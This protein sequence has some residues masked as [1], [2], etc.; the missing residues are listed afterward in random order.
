[1]AII[2]VLLLTVNISPSG[3]FYFR[4]SNVNQIWI[5]LFFFTV[6][7]ILTIPVSPIKWKLPKW[8]YAPAIILAIALPNILS[9]P[10]LLPFFQKA[11]KTGN[12]DEAFFYEW[13]K[14]DSL[15]DGEIENR[16][17]VFISANCKYC[18]FTMHKVNNTVAKTPLKYS[19]VL[20]VFAGTFKDPEAYFNLQ[21][22]RVFPHIQLP[23]QTVFSMS[24][25][26]SVPVILQ[27][28]AGKVVNTFNFRS[29]DDRK[30]IKTLLL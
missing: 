7:I 22:L 20:V 26:K 30:I 3:T 18:R 5:F 13:I 16:L 1:M 28:K 9:P 23:P 24:E 21:K 12:L 14:N 10:D 15:P 25:S 11:D 8:V 29:F 2:F 6:A 27:T 17:V 4:G 19:D